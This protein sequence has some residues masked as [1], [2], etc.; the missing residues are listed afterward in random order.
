[1]ALNS[2]TLTYSE[3]K[4]LHSLRALER[5]GNGFTD[6]G[7]GPCS[8]DSGGSLICEESGSPVAYGIISWTVGCGSEGSMGVY[9]DIWSEIDWIKRVAPEAFQVETTTS[10]S[11]TTT[12][13]TAITLAVTTS[14]SFFS[15][16]TFWTTL[17]IL[18]SQ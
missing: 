11:T 17:F 1:M 5:D 9:T 7:A 4:I 15:F 16:S 6:D 12:S 2:W 3:Q 14:S 13:P 18:L 10:T 8:G